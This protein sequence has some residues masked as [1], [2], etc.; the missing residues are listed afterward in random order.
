[1]VVKKNYGVFLKSFLLFSYCIIMT[2]GLTCCAPVLNYP[3]S[4]QF[5]P[6]NVISDAGDNRVDP[7]ITVAGFHDERTVG[8]KAVVGKRL[9]SNGHEINVVSK[10]RK[11][12]VAVASAIRDFFVRSGYTVKKDIPT[13]DLETYTIS[14]DW[15]TLVIGG[16]INDLQLICRSGL[17]TEQYEAMAKLTIVCADVLQKRI[18]YRTTLESTS[19]LKHVRFSKKIIQQE[20][21]NALSTAVEKIFGSIEF[22]Q[23]LK[24]NKM[25]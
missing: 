25:Y 3:I 12:D 18:L 15:G 19:E 17:V 24:G 1:M 5:V 8:D 4:L 16:V 22:R 21:N 6:Q 7:V 9:K 14:P 2:L 10:N 20:L 23:I 13:W 11:P